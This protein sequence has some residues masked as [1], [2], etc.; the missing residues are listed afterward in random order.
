MVKN[1][2]KLYFCCVQDKNC[3]YFS[4]Y[5][6]SDEEISE[7]APKLK[8]TVDKSGINGEVIKFRNLQKR[9]STTKAAWVMQTH[10][11]LSSSLSSNTHEEGK[12]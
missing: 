2:N 1:S 12:K 11:Q 6:P 4:F 7:D 8:N 5:S 9:S 10:T 3:G